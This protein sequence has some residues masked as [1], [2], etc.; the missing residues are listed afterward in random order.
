MVIMNQGELFMCETQTEKFIKFNSPPVDMSNDG[1]SLMSGDQRGS[2]MDIQSNRSDDSELIATKNKSSVMSSQKVHQRK[3]TS[4]RDA[5]ILA[6][7]HPY[8]IVEIKDSYLLSC[9]ETG[10]GQLHRLWYEED[11]DV[12]V[13]QSGAGA[14]LK[15]GDRNAERG[16][17]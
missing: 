1:E 8:P 13:R 5:Y 7:L 16:I 6:M 12:D 17:S 14:P 3:Q 2:Y 4:K 15:H 9:T 11:K 10:R